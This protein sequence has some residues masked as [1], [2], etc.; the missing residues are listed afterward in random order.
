MQQIDKHGIRAEYLNKI[1][2][3][4]SEIIAPT[5]K[6]KINDALSEVFVCWNKIVHVWRKS[7]REVYCCQPEYKDKNSYD[8][9]AENLV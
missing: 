8:Y 1:T 5:A 3:K 7:D 2:K 6:I 4:I 9:D